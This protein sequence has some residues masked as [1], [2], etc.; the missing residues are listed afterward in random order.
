MSITILCNQLGEQNK[1]VFQ[2]RY[3]TCSKTFAFVKTNR[4][5]KN[6]KDILP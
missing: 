1:L 5:I 6:H 2:S 4:R 3:W